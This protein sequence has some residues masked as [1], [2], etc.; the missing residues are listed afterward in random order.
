MKLATTATVGSNHIARTSRDRERTPDV[1]R[2]VAMLDEE[3]RA[4]DAPSVNDPTAVE[5]TFEFGRS[6]LDAATTALKTG[7]SLRLDQLADEP[8]DVLAA[9]RLVARGELVVVDGQL[10][11]RIVELLMLLVAWFAIGIPTSMADE[12][13]RADSASTLFDGEPPDLWKTPFSPARNNRSNSEE[14]V[15]SDD[16]RLKTFSRTNSTSR[17]AAL[18]PLSTPLT[19]R[20]SKP[21]SGDSSPSRSSWSAT[22]L[23]LLFVVGLIVVG[24][25]YLKSRS[26]NAA[27]GLP[28][29]AFEV[30][31]RKA[32][33]ARTSVLLARS[34]NRLLL[35]SLSPHGLQTLAEISDPVEVDC[36]AGLCRATQRDQSLVEIFRS[37]LHKPEG[38]K[39]SLRSPKSQPGTAP[40]IEERLAARHTIGVHASTSPEVRS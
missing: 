5:V 27:R 28:S 14:S 40:S 21:E 29:E 4:E 18:E 3:L 36:L 20:T 33:D 19:P 2:W 37:M 34:G 1:N 31:G 13:P 23:P 8:L 15:L 11:I 39:P 30:L 26:P 9:G 38:S 12:R 22:V 25:R 32:I 24:A 16:V 6:T 7:G 17:K 35:L 10:G